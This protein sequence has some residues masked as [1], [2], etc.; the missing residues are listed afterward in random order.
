MCPSR[1]DGP[2]VA[3]SQHFGLV[4]AYH[5]PEIALGSAGQVR[6]HDAADQAAGT[7]D[8]EVAVGDGLQSQGVVLETAG[9]DGEH[10]RMAGNQP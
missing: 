8:R 1:I 10:R 3:R 4:G 5:R 6:A 2:A 9:L 7:E